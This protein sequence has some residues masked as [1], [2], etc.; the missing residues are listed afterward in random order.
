MRLPG[1]VTVVEVGPRD[2]L[3]NEPRPVA[4]AVKIALIDRLGAAGLAVIEAGSFVS[5]RR[6]PQMG[7]SA[8]VL[9]GLRRRPGTRYPV[10]VPNAEGFR[11]AVA[12]GA[13]EVAVF[14]AASESFS[15]RNLNCS[16][17]G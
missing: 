13:A 5:P 16:I 10:L 11:R 1:A 2:G 3:Q 9:A 8:A 12:A 17:E 7:D 15:R 6:V 4:A 14:A